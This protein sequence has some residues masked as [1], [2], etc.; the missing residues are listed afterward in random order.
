MVYEKWGFSRA[1]FEQSSLPSTELGEKL[2]IGRDQQLSLLMKRI[3]SAPKIAVL[4][5]LNG[6]GK[7][8]VVNV[9]AYRLYKEHLLGNGELYLP[10]R[11]S[12]Q[13]NSSESSP[14][15]IEKVFLEIAQTLIDRKNDFTKT[16]EKLQID[17]L[18]RWL[19][20]PERKTFQGGA[21]VLQA[22]MQVT[23]NTTS[24]FEKSGL[25]KLVRDLLK[26]AFPT[27][28][29]GGIICCIDNLE[30]LQESMKA[31]Q[32]LEELRDTL[33]QVQGICWVLCGALGIT[34]GVAS[35]PRLESFLH[36]PIELKEM[37]KSFA[38]SILSSRMDI[39]RTPGR[40][41]DSQY[42][43]LRPLEFDELYGILRGNLRTVLSYTDNYC[44]DVAE[45]EVPPKTDKEKRDRFYTW[46]QGEA[47]A[48]YSV[49]KS[50]LTRK[51]L[52]VFSEAAHGDG[53]FSPGDFERFGFNA[54][55]NFRPY[56][57]NLEDVYLVVSTQD[58]SDK[59]RKTIQ[60]TP[61]GWL[62][63]YH[64]QRM[65]SNN[66]PRWLSDIEAGLA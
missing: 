53:T 3:R 57:K 30:L 8:S 16:E 64:L 35:S 29:Q 49:A 59:R 66:P 65:N 10:C 34:Y 11:T 42:L 28:N 43:P 36:R 2:L 5:G 18:D 9:A 45:D 51:T 12:F 37:D 23:T 1:P 4:E 15:F 55:Q 32:L 33:L 13:L 19:N 40:P 21:W 14:Q 60:I 52:A 63:H 27:P 39:Y 31:R 56:I 25:E 7:T 61:K 24:G 26:K 48:A 54:M 46:L 6:I 41:K 17:E 38:P 58:D 50:V 47:E 22:G 62:V 20:S 44:Q